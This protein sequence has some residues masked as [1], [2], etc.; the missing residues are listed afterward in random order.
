[1]SEEV[2][3]KERRSLMVMLLDA[4]MRLAIAAQASPQPR[5]VTAGTNRR[6]RLGWLA[7]GVLLAVAGTAVVVG[8]L[9]KG[10]DD[11]SSLPPHTPGRAPVADPSTSGLR[12]AGV[13]A[14]PLPH[15]ATPTA[16]SAPATPLPSLSGRVPVSAGPQREPGVP[17]VAATEPLTARYAAT[18]GGTGLLGYRAGV[19]ITNPDPA[20]RKGWQ[21]TLQLPRPTLTIARVSG[22]TVSQDGKV[23]TFEP[24]ETTETVPAGGSVLISFEVRGATLLAAAPQ[25]CRIDDVACTGIAG[26]TDSG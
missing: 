21:L 22:A 20:G 8:A 15:G 13:T 5:V 4:A 12:S 26:S 2:P 18:D 7:L 10:P 1:M 19:T 6:G 11:L 9:L 24:D 16:T 3:R 25:D 23:W 14:A 17:P